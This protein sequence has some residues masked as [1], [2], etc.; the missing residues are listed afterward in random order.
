MKLSRML[1]FRG[2]KYAF[3]I[4]AMIL[5]IAWALIFFSLVDSL[6]LRY[7]EVM[8][9]V[10]TTL[11]LGIFLGSLT[12]GFLITMLAKDRRGTTYGIY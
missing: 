1:D 7:G 12:I 3:L 10:D 6:L 5:N 2:T 4:L 8:Q 11:M 9:G